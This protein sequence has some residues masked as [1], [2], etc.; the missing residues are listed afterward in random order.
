MEVPEIEAA[1]KATE[2][3]SENEKDSS[4]LKSSSRKSMPAPETPVT[5][6]SIEKAVFGETEKPSISE[7][8]AE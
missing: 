2:K 3:L 4:K 8:L 1:K 7:G 6:K 5:G